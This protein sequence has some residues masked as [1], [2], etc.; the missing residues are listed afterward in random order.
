[1]KILMTG[2]TGF[3]GSHLT[4]ALV[5]EG[6]EVIIIKRSFSNTWRI[7]DILSK[8]VVYNMD[9]CSLEKPFEEHGPIDVVIHTATKYDRNGES[10][11][12]L[13]H[14]N[15]SF[16]LQLLEKSI[17]YHTKLFINT[18]S[19]INKKNEGY[20]YLVSYALTKKQFLEWGREFSLAGKICFINIKLEHI[21]GPFDNEDKFTTYI[22]KSCLKN[23]PELHLT[24]GFQKRDFIHV[25]D[26]LTAYS[27]ILN[28]NMKGLP[29]FQEYELG[30]GECKTI[31]EFIEL[32]HEKSQSKTLLKFGAI[33]LRQNEIMESKA[34]IEELKKLGWKSKINLE[35]G[36]ELVLQ[37]EKNRFIV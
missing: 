20:Q 15:V 32:I 7:V 16:P 10:S 19:F 22:I 18:D 33:P 23:I 31:R 34:N 36:I 5:K 13:L 6:H 21:Y 12:Q 17:S 29:G 25:N 9:Q 1:M 4:R 2:S 28:K 27:I 30:L 26:V 8:V 11:S 35:Q 14:S 24:E 37:A 3:L